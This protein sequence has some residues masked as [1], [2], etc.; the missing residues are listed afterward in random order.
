MTTRK[1]RNLSSTAKSYVEEELKQSWDASSF[2]RYLARGQ[3]DLF[4]FDRAI[5]IERLEKREVSGFFIFTCARKGPYDL[6]TSKIAHES[7]TDAG[8]TRSVAE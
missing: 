1:I 2:G 8:C 4:Q 7:A 6:T 3:I 5:R